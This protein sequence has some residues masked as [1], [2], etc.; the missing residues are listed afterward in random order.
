MSGTK[1][2]W[3]AAG[4]GI[5]R[6]GPFPSRRRARESMQLVVETPEQYALH[7]HHV[8]LANAMA[9]AVYRRLILGGVQIPACMPRAERQTLRYPPD[10]RVWKEA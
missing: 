4:A 6:M 3:F 5:A 8:A 1:E 9:E 2:K 10:L 7:V